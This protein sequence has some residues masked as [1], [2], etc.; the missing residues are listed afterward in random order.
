[1]LSD[2]VRKGRAMAIAD[3]RVLNEEGT[4]LVRGTCYFQIPRSKSETK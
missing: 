2:I 1:V 4:V 3:S